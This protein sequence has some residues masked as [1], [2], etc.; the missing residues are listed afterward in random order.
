MRGDVMGVLYGL[1]SLKSYVK[2]GRIGQ[3]EAKMVQ[4]FAVAVGSNLTRI[5]AIRTRVQFEQF[6]SPE[7]V[8]QLEQDPNLLTGR[9]QEVTVLASDM[10]GFT[11]LSETLDPQ[12]TSE[13]LQDL[14]N[15]LSDQIVQHGGVIIDYAGDGILAMWNAPLQQTD[16]AAQACRAALAMVGELPALNQ[17]WQRRIGKPLELGIGVNTGIAQVGN[18]GSRRKFKYGPHGYT[19]NLASRV[20][21]ATKRLKV[22]VLVTDAT[23]KQLPDNFETRFAGRVTLPGVSDVSD[24]YE[25][26]MDTSALQ[27]Y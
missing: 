9:K 24:L 6:F 5:A 27:A 14:M 23:R 10:R 2:G 15:C 8:C 11:S 13:L 3:L 18:T 12:V 20:Q 21:D 7:L 1:R 25:L 4:L 17:T 22:P 16:H 26:I 19:V